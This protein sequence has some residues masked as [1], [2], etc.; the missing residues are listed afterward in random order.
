MGEEPEYESYCH[1]RL[2]VN[3]RASVTGLKDEGTGTSVGIRKDLSR[4]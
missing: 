1:F 3:V 2:G 4:E